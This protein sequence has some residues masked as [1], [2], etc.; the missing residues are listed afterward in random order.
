M[1]SITLDQGKGLQ[2]GTGKPKLDAPSGVIAGLI[3]VAIMTAGLA[4][5][6]WSLY[7]DISGTGMPATTWLPFILLGVALLI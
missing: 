3:F 5:T 1:S 7:Q 2:P 6:V 4:Y